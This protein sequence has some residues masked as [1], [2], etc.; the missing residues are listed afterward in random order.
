MPGWISIKFNNEFVF[1]DP[2]PL[3]VN[4]LENMIWK[5]WPIFIMFGFIFINV[6]IKVDH[7]LYLLFNAIFYCKFYL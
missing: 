6:V 2:Q 5:I 1:P 7:F 3:I 4:I